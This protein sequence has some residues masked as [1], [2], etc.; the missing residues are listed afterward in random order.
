MKTGII[1][2][3]KRAGLKSSQK[4]WEQIANALEKHSV[5]YDFVQSESQDSVER[6][7]TMMIHNDYDNIII[8]GGDTALNDATNCLMR[9]E[10]AVRERVTLGVIPNGLMNDFAS[11]W[12]FREN[13]IDK[14]A[15]SIA[16]HRTR[17]IDAACL[18]YTDKDGKS[19]NHYFLNSVN[20]G[21]VAQIQ[22]LRQQ[23]RKIFWS[24][25]ASFVISFVLLFFQRMTYHLRYTI[26]YE[27]E[28]HNLMT[29]CVGNAL[30]YGL[31]PNGVPYNGLLDVSAVKQA[32]TTQIFTGIALFLRGKFLNHRGI[33]PYRCH[34]MDIELPKMKDTPVSIDGILLNVS[35]RH[36]DLHMHV[37]QE[38]INFLIEK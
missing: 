18:Q 9:E 20:I 14:V 24:R 13:N 37:E 10:Y 1:Y 28:E 36:T 33:L 3:P 34:E 4:R 22:R 2:C 8:A 15:E 5:N 19:H 17:K 29:L 32:V 6:L 25:K 27:T 11:F 23:T 16:A 7:V 30:G 35:C 21:L 31:T 26:S 12:G 38:A